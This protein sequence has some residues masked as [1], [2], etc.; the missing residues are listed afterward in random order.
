[1]NDVGWADE[2]ESDIILG[3]RDQNT[4]ETTLNIKYTF[5]NKMGLTFRLR[6]Y[7]SQVEYKEYYALQMDGTLASTDYSNFD[8]YG[9]DLNNINFNSFNI[10]MVY[11]WVFSP[12]SEINFIW[13]NIIQSNDFNVNVKY[14]ENLENTLR[15][16]QINSFTLK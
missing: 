15:Q 10:D 11:R 8:D 6:Q 1:M 14:L 5:T 7:W 12:G 4:F 2:T 16:D 3:K 13:K 9:H